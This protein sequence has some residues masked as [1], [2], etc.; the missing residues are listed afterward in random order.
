[1]IGLYILLSHFTKVTPITF[2][3]KIKKKLTY[4]TCNKDKGVYIYMKT[5]SI[6]ITSWI[7]TQHFTFSFK[8]EINRDYK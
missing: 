8:S 7:L 5:M 4:F 1:M 3:T 2:V 6:K